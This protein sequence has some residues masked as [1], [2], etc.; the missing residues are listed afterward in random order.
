[1]LG[2]PAKEGTEKGWHPQT[3][4]SLVIPAHGGQQ[5]TLEV[6]GVEGDLPLAAGPVP[7]RQLGRG[8]GVALVAC[9]EAL[10]SLR[11]ALPD[12][13]VRVAKPN[14]FDFVALLGDDHELLRGSRR[15]LGLV[16]A[17]HASALE[18]RI[19]FLRHG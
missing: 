15:A 14:G 16:V 13:H 10:A 18:T 9:S 4:R 6:V 5:H 11:V 2:S 12:L 19:R 7:R 1:M 3:L 17:A 8:V